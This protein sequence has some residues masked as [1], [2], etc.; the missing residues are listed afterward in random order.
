MTDKP[1]PRPSKK[2]PAKPAKADRVAIVKALQELS[3]E[4]GSPDGNVS[5]SVNTDGVM[6]RLRLAPG[7][8]KLSP[9]QLADLVLRTYT[10]AQRESAQRS[11]ELLGPLGNAGYLSDR[12]RWRIGFQP[13]SAAASPGAAEAKGGKAGSGV[14]R[15]RSGT[16]REPERR[17]EPESDDEFYEKGVRFDPSW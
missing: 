8:A 2:P 14:L 4:A 16:W 3:V 1:T 13:P 15:D 11:A 5:L 6:T 10:Q 17:S 12:L 9:A 7:A